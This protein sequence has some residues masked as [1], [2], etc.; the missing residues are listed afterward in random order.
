M[1]V[2][3]MK[4][5]RE[6]SYRAQLKRSY[7]RFRRRK[8]EKQRISKRISRIF[9]HIYHKRI[10]VAGTTLKPHGKQW[11][12]EQIAKVRFLRN[13]VELIYSHE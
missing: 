8:S 3:T 7:K 11:I 9:E 2:K 4:D 13:G 5:K 10:G 1:G 12:R 6:K